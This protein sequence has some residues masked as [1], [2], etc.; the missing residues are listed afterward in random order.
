VERR[1]LRAAALDGPWLTEHLE[2][3]RASLSHGA[4]GVAL[5]LLR[6]SCAREDPALLALADIWGSQA[7]REISTASGFYNEEWDLTRERVGEISPYHCASGVHATRAWIAHARGDLQARNRAVEAFID[8]SRATDESW[9]L[10]LG[11]A[12]TL[13]I[14]ALL[15]D[16]LSGRDSRAAARLVA[17]GRQ[18]LR[19]LWQE[20]DGSP[21]LDQ[22][23]GD[24][25][26]IAHGWAGQLY[27]TLQWCRASGDEA[28]ASL[29][30]RLGQ[31]ADRAEP[32]GRGARW[33]ATAGARL[34]GG[35]CHGSA[36]FVFL[37]TLA[38]R[39]LG[40]PAFLELAEAAGWT[41]WEEPGRLPTLCCGLVGR[42]YALLNLF[43]HTREQRWLQRARELAGRAV[44]A[45]SWEEERRYSLHR[46]ELGLA[47]LAADLDRPHAA[48]MPF[49]EE[50]GWR[51]T[52]LPEN[53]VG[54]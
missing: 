5:A 16:V 6:I 38:H 29:A 52:G 46:G 11:R 1:I 43:K 42:A 31:L 27:A 18:T 28:P 40:D 12:G 13:L 30:G 47:V 23:P 44:A 3:P 2:P 21:A 32:V 26:G 24:Y 36:G 8:A 17:L 51:D 45:Q 54:S 33:T 19:G 53:Q 25:P 15:V 20:I 50:E 39:Q 4:A 48:V 35:W 41:A 14:A 34:V 22:L 49:F 9:D 37:W 10:T 7:L